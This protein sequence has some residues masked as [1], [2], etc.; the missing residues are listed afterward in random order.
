M[1][2]RDESKSKGEKISKPKYWFNFSWKLLVLRSSHFSFINNIRQIKMLS[3][4]NFKML[5]RCLGRSFIRP[6]VGRITAQSITS[7]RF[8]AAQAKKSPRKAAP[9]KKIENLGTQEKI[10]YNWGRFTKWFEKSVRFRCVYRKRNWINLVFLSF[11]NP[12]KSLNAF[13]QVVLALGVIWGLFRAIK[14]IFIEDQRAAMIDMTGQMVVI[15][16]ASSGFGKNLAYECA[17]R[18]ATVEV[19]REDLD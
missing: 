12:A 2:K 18:N 7:Y 9:A 13:F 6:N 8:N 15:T 14:I 10:H 11:S 4:S 5:S 16:G 19:K 1:K 3:Y 17:A